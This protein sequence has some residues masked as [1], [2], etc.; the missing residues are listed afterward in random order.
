MFTY[1]FIVTV[2]SWVNEKKP[3]V[4]VKKVMWT[5]AL[6]CSLL[7]LAFGLLGAWAFDLVGPK[8]T[9]TKSDCQNMLIFDHPDMPVI[10]RYSSY[11]F[12]LTTLVP[13]IP[14]LAIVAAL[15]PPVVRAVL[16]DRRHVLGRDRAVGDR[17][18][19]VQHAVL[20]QG[21]RAPAR[22]GASPPH[23]TLAHARRSPVRLQMLNWISILL[24]GFVNFVAPPLLLA[25]ALV[26]YPA[27]GGGAT[28]PSDADADDAAASCGGAAAAAAG[29]ARRRRRRRR[30]T[31]A[32]Y[33]RI[34]TDRRR[35][36][37]PRLEA[38]RAVAHFARRPAAGD[39]AGH[40]T[41]GVNDSVAELLPPNVRKGSADVGVPG[42]GGAALRLAAPLRAALRPHHARRRRRRDHLQGLR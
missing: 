30:R 16:A 36:R 37:P 12:M 31:A 26:R 9:W 29:A 38:A 14:V 2:P 1:A 11:L 7:Q 22:L 27:A 3:A 39:A 19:P 40:G 33:L 24:M 32:N 17:A 20:R 18:L 41:L 5:S 25:T 28:K 42:V 13:G 6:T 21:A 8:A 23:L 15:Q 4:S 10:T 34:R 35:R